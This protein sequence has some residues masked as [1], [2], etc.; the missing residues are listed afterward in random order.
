MKPIAQALDI[1][2]GDKHVSLVYLAL[3][4]SEIN[5]S[6]NEMNNLYFCRPLV[7]ALMK[8]T[9]VINFNCEFEIYNIHLWLQ[10]I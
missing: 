10:N 2:Q 6:L 7:N 3:I 1:L 9:E 8:G 5:K 4:I